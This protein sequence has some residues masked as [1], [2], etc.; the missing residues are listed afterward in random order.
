MESSDPALGFA[1]VALTADM[2]KQKYQSST[3]DSSLDSA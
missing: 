2:P 3:N 1:L